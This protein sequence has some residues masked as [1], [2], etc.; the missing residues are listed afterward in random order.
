M[1]EPEPS[2]RLDLIPDPDQIHLRLTAATRI[3]RLLRRQLRLSLAAR[4]EREAVQ[5]DSPATT[6]LAQAA[7]V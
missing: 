3:Q 7:G 4:R 5:P 6:E 1:S 2:D